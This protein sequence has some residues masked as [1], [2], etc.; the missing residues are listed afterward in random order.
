[1]APDAQII[2]VSDSVAAG[3]ATD[4]SGPA[5]V[6]LLTA[7][8]FTVVAHSV[9]PDGEDEVADALA[10]AADG[11]AG[12]LVTTGGTGFGPRD[13]TPEGTE[14]VLERHAPGLAEAMRA[15]SPRG[16][17]SRGVAGTRGPCLICNLPG[18]VDGATESL[19]AVL[20]VLPHAVDLLTGG[21]PHPYEPPTGGAP[22]AE[23]GPGSAA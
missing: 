13:C 22:N 14:A 10:A 23:P 6:D 12:L 4:R 18:S 2:T 17:L 16:R 20:D 11:F 8:G 15:A 9:V 7:A 21:N 5:V 1:V 19:R 3:T